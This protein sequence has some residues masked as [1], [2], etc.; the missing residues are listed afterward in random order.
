MLK[1]YKQKGIIKET[2]TID[3]ELIEEIPEEKSDE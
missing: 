3:A 1:D 2:Q